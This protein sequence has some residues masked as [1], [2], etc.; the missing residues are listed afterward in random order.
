MF[1]DPVI[2]ILIE[3]AARG[4]ELRRRHER[5]ETPINVSLSQGSTLTRAGD[6]PARQ[7][8]PVVNASI[9]HAAA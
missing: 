1:N 4:R 3:A 5:N 7:A 6:E 8:E 2:Q 9:P